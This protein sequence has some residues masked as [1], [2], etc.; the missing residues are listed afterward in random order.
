MELPDLEV[1]EYSRVREVPLHTAS[2]ETVSSPMFSSVMI[3]SFCL[4]GVEIEFR[5]TLYA[6]VR[7]GKFQSPLYVHS[8]RKHGTSLFGNQIPPLGRLGHYTS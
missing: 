2:Q 1:G 6:L 3:A 7:E 5:D 4:N 8:V